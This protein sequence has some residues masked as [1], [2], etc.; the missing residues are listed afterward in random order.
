M[1][2]FPIFV[3]FNIEFHFQSNYSLAIDLLFYQH[4]IFAG[5]ND[6][7]LKKLLKHTVRLFVFKQGNK[8]LVERDK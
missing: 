4:K 7:P 5:T 8:P 2:A 3:L 1:V 6:M